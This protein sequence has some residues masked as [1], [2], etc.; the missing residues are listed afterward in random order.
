MGLYIQSNLLGISICSCK[1]LTTSIAFVSGIY[2]ELLTTIDGL[3]LGVFSTWKKKGFK[4]MWAQYNLSFLTSLFI[5]IFISVLSLAKAISYVLEVYPILTWSFFFGLVV[6]SIL[7]IGKQIKQWGGAL[8]IA[9]LLGV[10][11]AYYIT[12]A[13][14]VEAPDAIYFYFLS[15]CIAIIAM[16][17]PGI[18]GAFIL[19]IL[20]AYAMVLGALNNFIS[21]LLEQD[22]EGVKTNFVKVFVF[23]LGCLVGIKVFSKALKWMF[24]NK[25]EFTLA[26]LT[27]FMIGSLNKI[28][29]WKRVLSTRI[30]RHGEEQIVQA[31]S[32]LPSSFDG[33]PELAMAI[34]FAIIGFALIFLL[35]HFATRK[36]VHANQ[37]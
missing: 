3:N 13:A 35:E 1:I 27:G 36:T 24:K 20:G 23:I 33:N 28:W 37:D 14:P 5:G 34:L 25:K 26:I 9:L 31:D 17:L 11:V 30:D 19:V 29:P 2:E 22:W 18:S 16:I 15:G 8:I 32:I 12:I 21:S 6:A 4:E 7:Y 10:V